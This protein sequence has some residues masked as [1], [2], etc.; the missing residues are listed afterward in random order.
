MAQILSDRDA[1]RVQA[2][3][4]W[5]DSNTDI[6]YQR[7]RHKDRGGARGTNVHQ[8]FSK[9]AA[10]ANTD[11]FVCH[12]DT[13]NTGE[14]ITVYPLYN[15]TVTVLSLAAPRLYDGTPVAVWQDTSGTWW[16]CVTFE[17]A[18]PC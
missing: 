6:R 10:A 15:T 11:A 13:D 14:E 9:S 2:M 16:T 12:L 1:A 18:G 5:F 17:K 7:R 3:L 8:A 4:R